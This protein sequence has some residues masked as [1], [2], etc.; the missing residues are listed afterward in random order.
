MKIL[1][2]LETSIPHTVGYTV[3][4]NSIIE[5]QRRI[6][7]DVVVVTSPFFPAQRRDVTVEE[8]DHVRYYRTNRI[9]TPATAKSKLGSY[10]TRLLMLRR[11]RQAVSEIVAKER[12]DVIHAHSSYSNAYAAMPA[13]RRFRLPL[14]YEVRTLWGESAVVEDGWRPNSW[15]H[16]MIWRLELGA[17]KR[18]DLVVPIARGIRDELVERGIPTEKL[19]IVPNGVDCQ[20]FRPV[21]RDGALADSIGLGGR[22][23][24]GFVGSMRRLE[25]LSTLLDAYG[26]ARAKGLNLGLV[27]VG[28]GPDKK[29]LEKKARELGLADVV[30]TGSVPHDQV[31]AWYSIIDVV[32]YPR[33]RAVINERVTPLKPLE[34]MA[35]GKVCIGSDVGG[36]TELISDGRTGMIFRSGDAA[37]L[38]EVIAALQADP[39]RLKQLGENGQ[40]YVRTERDWR[41]IVKRYRELYD[42][43]TGHVGGAP[44][45]AGSASA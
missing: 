14:V 27:L 44:Q 42:R 35:L 5:N 12:V 18:A 10:A 39:A 38:A 17:M 8:Y 28:D 32:A 31:A 45:Q 40:N 7:L 24:V 9:P 11:Y 6:G 37:H 43:L 19:E 2:V 13:A 29:D 36:L 41:V 3:R 15:K 20:K 21:A 22:F 30:F 33:I 25:G 4:A 16:R 34:V 1:H 26:L 23:I